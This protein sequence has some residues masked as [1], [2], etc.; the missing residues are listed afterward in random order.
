VTVIAPSVRPSPINERNDGPSG[1]VLIIG[2]VIFVL[3]I[4]AAVVLTG[5]HRL[6]LLGVVVTVLA[7]LGLLVYLGARTLLKR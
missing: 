3:A 2:C 6:L 5:S 4:L 7:T 1:S